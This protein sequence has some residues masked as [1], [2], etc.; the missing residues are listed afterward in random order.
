M[1]KNS[2]LNVSI[3]GVGFGAFFI[4]PL[5]QHNKVDRITVCATRRK[6]IESTMAQYAEIDTGYVNIDEM[7]DKEKPDVVIIVSPDYLHREHVTKCAEAKAHVLL[8]KPMAGNLDDAAVMIQV[9]EEFGIKLMVAHEMRYRPRNRTLRNLINDGQLGKINQIQFDTIQNKVVQFARSPWYISGVNKS[10]AM[11]QIGIHNV[12]LIR[13]FVGQPIK[14]VFAYGNDIGESVD[15][16]NGKKT[17]S[18]QYHFEGDTIGIVS[19]IF[20]A[21][22]PK[23]MDY[24]NVR[25]YNYFR[26]IGT[27]GIV[28]D[29]RYSFADRQTWTELPWDN[30]HRCP[31]GCAGSVEEFL[32]FLDGQD[33]DA[34]SGEEAY[35]SMAA[36]VAADE[37]MVAGKPVT[38]STYA[39]R[40]KNKRGRRR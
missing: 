15:Y 11:V 8:T 40:V 39:D 14:S 13:Y 7:L 1:D 37:S 2:K 10:S 32:K 34:V 20:D 31:D 18:A 26:I 16:P 5:A 6:R 3:I 4:K 36:C 25:E 30:P 19:T 24:G 12:D 23:D 28:I 29:N 35:N 21:P 38:P 33:S 17:I 22:L 9:A 27:K